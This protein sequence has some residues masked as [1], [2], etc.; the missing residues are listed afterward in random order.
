MDTVRFGRALGAGARE[1]AKALGKAADAAVAPNPVVT[2]KVGQRVAHAGAG[3]RQA[4]V[5]VKRG[6]KRF[7]EAVWGP[8]VK[9]SGVLW[10]EVT[11]V[12]F[13]VF[14]LTAAVDVWKRRAEFGVGGAARQHVWF[15]VA[16]MLVFGWFTVSSFTRAHRRG[17]R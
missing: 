1:A 15:A 13:G 12:F 3:V 17:R 11:G 16:M 10:L 7:G 9:L 6:G 2:R 8:F 14:A 4:G 5:G